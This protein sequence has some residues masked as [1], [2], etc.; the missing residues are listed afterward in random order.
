MA[1]LRNIHKDD[2]I[3]AVLMAEVRG[4][5][6][7]S[8]DRANAEKLI[9]D[10]G[11]DIRNPQSQHMFGQLI[12]FAVNDLQAQDGDA[13]LNAIADHKTIGLNEKAEFNAPVGGIHA[14]IQAKG[15][16]TPRSRIG[17]KKI[18]VETDEISARPA[19]GI[20]DLQS[21]KIDMAAVIVAAYQALNAKRLELVADVLN[22]AVTNLKAPFYAKGT[23][24]L[25]TGLN[26]LVRHWMRK[27]GAAIVGDIEIASRLAELTGFAAN[28]TTRQFA[29]RLIDE[30]NQ[31]GYIGK[32]IGASVVSLANPYTDEGETTLA[33]PVNKL[34]VFPALADAN[35]RPLKTVTEGPVQ[36]QQVLNIDDK[37]LDIR[38]DQYAGAAFVY[39][40]QPNMSVYEDESI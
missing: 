14:V 24:V 6:I 29:D 8:G 38:L 20:V 34:F 3:N 5:R 13:A 21:G 32:Y 11:A 23:G 33:L 9:K 40:N 28:T 19:L 22:S 31:N 1:E 37:T 15:S 17:N 4:E 39:G 36:V 2:K 16:T 10:L 12:E 25:A 26:P 30:Y 27:G 18:V 35:S 7:D